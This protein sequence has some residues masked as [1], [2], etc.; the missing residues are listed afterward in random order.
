MENE[1]KVVRVNAQGFR[2]TVSIGDGK[3]EFEGGT[4]RTL[5]ADIAKMAEHHNASV[6]IEGGNAAAIA[7]ELQQ[8]DVNV[9][10]IE[11]VGEPAVE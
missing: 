5:A 9:E 7:E 1:S 6:V 3:G 8:L 4:P 10:V 11:T 2:T